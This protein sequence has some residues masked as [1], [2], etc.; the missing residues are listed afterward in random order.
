MF[1]RSR[2]SLLAALVVAG[3]TLLGLAPRPAHASTTAAADQPH[4]V[5]V[6]RLS[7]H[8]RDLVVWSP[9][10]R[11]EETVRLLVPHGWR[12]DPDRTWP[13]LW[14][15]HGCCETEGY[16]AWARNT[17]VEELTRDLPVIVV[18]PPAGWDGFYSDWLNHGQGGGPRWETFHLTELRGILESHFGAGRRRAVAGLS[19]GGF[20]AMSYAGRHLG[21]FRA[22]ASYSGVTHTTYSTLQGPAL[23]QGVLLTGGHD[24]TA[25]WGDPILDADVWAAHNPYDLAGRLARIPLYVACGTGQ[26]G[27]LNDL[28]LPDS[29][30]QQLAAQ[31]D[32]FVARLR[33]LGAHVQT[34]LGYPGTHAWPYWR[35]ELHRSF[36]ML[37]RSLGISA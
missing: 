30:E 36:P 32:A 11:S 27:P 12:R 1:R 21:M 23:V 6:H 34:H 35:R 16:S 9:A 37:M 29:V 15:L 3:A 2:A 19:M 28:P 26:S 5:A 24:P 14:L 7:A 22:A 8:V 4:V 20:G 18:M 17:D 10:M 25:L 13:V 31:N 33:S